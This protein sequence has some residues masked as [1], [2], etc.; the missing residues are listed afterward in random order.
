MPTVPQSNL[1][2]VNN[3]GQNT[4]SSPAQVGL[5]VGPTVSGTANQIILDDSITTV[6]ENFDSGPGSEEAATALVE[7]SAGTVY[8][9]KTPTSVAGTVSSVTKTPGAT[10]GT[11][12]DDFG[13]V[14]VAGASF[15]GDVL[16]TGKVEGAELEIVAGGASA[17]SVIGLHVLLTVTGAT[18]GTQLAALIT[19]V[20]AA[21]ALW[22]ATALGTGAAVCGQALATYAET[23]GRIGVQALVSGISVRTTIPAASQPR[24]V[25]LTGGN[26]VD[27]Q[28]ETN[29]NAE[30]ISTAIDVQ[31]DLV[32]LA[33]NNPGIFTSTLAGSGSGL[34]GAKALMGL[35]FGSAGTVAVSGSPNDAYQVSVQITQA[36]ALGVAAFSVSLG[37]AQGLPLYSGTFLVPPGGT[38]VIAGTG[39]TLTFA[40]AFDQFDTFTFTTT[41][42]LSTLSDVVTALTYFIA[43]P[44]QASLIQVAG[45]IPVVNIPAWV[46]A[47]QSIGNQLETAHKYVRILLE[48]AGPGS[49]QTNAQWATQVTGVLATLAAPRIL[50]F[51]GDCNAEAALPLPQAGRFE[52]VNGCRFVFARALALP[53]GVDVADQTLS[54]PASGVLEAYRT[55]AATALAGAGKL[56]LPEQGTWTPSDASGAGL[57]FTQ[58]N[59]GLYAKTGNQATCSMDITFPVTADTNIA[60]VSLPFA[61]VS[62]APFNGATGYQDLGVSVFPSAASGGASFVFWDVGGTVLTNAA[63]SGKRFTV[64]FSYRSA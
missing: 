64:S 39:L 51:G 53:S 56:G 59:T 31:S 29:A 58:N 1:R 42:P 6:I 9:I 3:L 32:T 34:L 14:L 38:F 62:G 63:L 36:G 28:L 35:P 41:A 23:A 60:R 5:V 22:G 12:I 50:V 10:V 44:E 49:G 37:S 27:I 17:T 7:P 20:P 26:I 33:N 8:Q 30:P 24:A 45:E 19:G 25:A 48:Y 18:T 40:S 2:A 46:A 21:L 54:G 15:N 4:P 55:D 13:A 61:T 57:T 11:V 16:F 52:I 47:L 43:R